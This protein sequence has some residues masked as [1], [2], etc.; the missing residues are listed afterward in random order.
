MQNETQLTLTFTPPNGSPFSRTPTVSAT[1]HTTADGL[2]TFGPYTYA[3]YVFIQG[4]I[5]QPGLWTA[6]LAYQDATPAYLL[7]TPVQ[8]TVDP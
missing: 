3:K 6:R 7:S 1:S 8:F 4:D 5:T 2:Q